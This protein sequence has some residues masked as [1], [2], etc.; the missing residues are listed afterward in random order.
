MVRRSPASIA[1]MLGGEKC[2]YRD[3]S[4]RPLACDRTAGVHHTYSILVNPSARSSSPAMYCGALQM[5][6]FLA[7]RIVV[8]SGGASCAAAF[9]R[10]IRREAASE[11]RVTSN[12]RRVCSDRITCLLC[13]GTSVD[14]LAPISFHHGNVP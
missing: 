1:R 12:R 5:L 13:L 8:V 4:P 10:P 7:S 2:M 3:S 14:A 11:E 9:V 6:A